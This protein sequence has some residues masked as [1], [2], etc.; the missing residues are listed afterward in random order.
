MFVMEMVLIG[1]TVSVIVKVTNS[2]N[3]VF[4]EVLVFQPVGLIVQL[5][6]MI[7]PVTS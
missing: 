7:A 6:L 3:A 2:M 4:V 5:L 1:Y